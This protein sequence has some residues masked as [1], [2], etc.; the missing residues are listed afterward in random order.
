MS[1]LPK[2]IDPRNMSPVKRVRI[3]ILAF[4]SVVALVTALA[5]L[6]VG[7]K[8]PL[9]TVTGAAMFIVPLVPP[10]KFE[11][12]Q[13]AMLLGTVAALLGGWFWLSDAT[14][15]NAAPAMANVMLGAVAVIMLGIMVYGFIRVLGSSSRHEEP[16]MRRRRR[17]VGGIRKQLRDLVRET[18]SVRGV[19]SNGTR[20]AE[21]DSDI[22]ML[23]VNSWS[24]LEHRN[25]TSYA[26]REHEN[27]VENYLVERLEITARVAITKHPHQCRYGEVAQSMAEEFSRLLPRVNIITGFDPLPDACPECREA[28]PAHRVNCMAAICWRCKYPT[29]PGKHGEDNTAIITPHCHIPQLC[30]P[31]GEQLSANAPLLTRIRLPFTIPQNGKDERLSMGEWPR[32]RSGLRDLLE[33]LQYEEDTV[34]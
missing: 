6:E 20:Y 34:I 13:V 15:G 32:S 2:N 1:F 21:Y 33:Q 8:A 5:D 26:W 22:N 19:Y 28:K 29:P 10:E 12:P 4:L 14:E 17:I 16:Y 25:R 7:I 27:L 30:F 11:L 9:L 3:G 23:F 24:M 31:R 18:T